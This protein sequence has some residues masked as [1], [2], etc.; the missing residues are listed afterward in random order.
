MASAG[1]PDGVAPP[2]HESGVGGVE[3]G[4]VQAAGGVL[5]GAG[6]EQQP[7]CPKRLVSHVEVGLGVVGLAGG[8]RRTDSLRISW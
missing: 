2:H 4:V 6:I 3:N 1:R 8:H 5:P 7:S